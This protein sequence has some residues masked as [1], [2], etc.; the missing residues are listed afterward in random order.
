SGPWLRR[1]VALAV[2]VMP[3]LSMAQDMQPIRIRG[4][5]LSAE[6]A[7]ITVRERGGETVRVRLGDPLDVSAVARSEIGRIVPG[8]YIGTAAV[9]QRDGTL[10][11]VEV[12][13]F[14][15]TMRGVREGH[16]PWDLTPET[17]M[18]NAVVESVVGKVSGRTV[19]L[20]Y[21]GG[22]QIVQIPPEAPI[23]TLE[24]GDRSLLVPGNHAFITA[25]RQSD[26]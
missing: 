12:L 15:E 11:A 10:R 21:K 17:T 13:I 19:T 20:K 23:V 2:L 16:Y 18:T 4:E 9:P 1:A 5:I 26:G 25:M 7:A 22:E 6:A 3:A 8:S 24:P 14:P